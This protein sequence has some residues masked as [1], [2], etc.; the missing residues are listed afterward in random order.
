MNRIDHGASR[1]L[2]EAA[3]PEDSVRVTFWWNGQEV[4]GQTGEPLAMALWALGI[5]TLGR[6]ERTGEPR[7]LYCAIGQCYECRVIVDGRRD[8]RS[9]LE[10]VRIG[11]RAE[12]QPS[13]EP[14]VFETGWKP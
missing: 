2:P 3:R 5:R 13:P 6:N 9:C 8:R 10:P 7:G 12:R 11:M 14:L 4:Q 1:A